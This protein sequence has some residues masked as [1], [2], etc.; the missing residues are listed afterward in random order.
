MD[1]VAP[2]AREAVLKLWNT[3]ILAGDGTNFNPKGNA[4]RAQAAALCMSTDK[5][6]E[7]W[8][9]E[10]GV[11]SDR[12]SV[13]PN[14]GQSTETPDSSTGDSGNDDNEKDSD[15]GKNTVG[16]QNQNK[17]TYYKV[18]FVIDSTK[19]EKVYKKDTLLSTLS[20]PT[21]PSGKVFLGWYYDEEKTKPVNGNDKLNAN[22]TLYAHL[23]DAIALDE[24]VLP[25]S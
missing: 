19:E 9:S 5:A 2:W 7:T 16:S 13:D 10:P 17:T 15:T 8:Y 25:T 20:I 24:A 14:N 22:L 23:T 1:T 18:T 12:V 3:G 21:M 4:S 6:V 11:P